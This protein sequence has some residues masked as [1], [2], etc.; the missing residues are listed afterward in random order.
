MKVIAMK[1]KTFR[2]KYRTCTFQWVTPLSLVSSDSKRMNARKWK[3][4]ANY[5]KKNSFSWFNI[6]TFS[7]YWHILNKILCTNLIILFLIFFQFQSLHKMCL[8]FLRIKNPLLD[9]C[10]SHMYVQYMHVYMWKLSQKYLSMAFRVFISI[11]VWYF[12]FIS[13]NLKT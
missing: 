4:Y 6:F 12:Y 1:S 7:L 11:C 10:C 13:F 3:A 8:T 5:P 2:D 9:H